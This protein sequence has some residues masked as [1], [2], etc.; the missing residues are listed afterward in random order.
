MPCKINNHSIEL[1]MRKK[2]IYGYCR[3]TS[4]LL[5]WIVLPRIFSN[6]SSRTIS[7]ICAQ[8]KKGQDRLLIYT[9]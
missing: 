9:V 7:A 3:M 6:T 4:R 5:D 8:V 1:H 2:Y